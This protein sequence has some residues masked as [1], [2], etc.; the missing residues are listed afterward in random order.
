[1]DEQENSKR[2]S[3]AYRHRSRKKKE[4]VARRNAFEETERD[5]EKDTDAEG[6]DEDADTEVND[7]TCGIKGPF[8]DKRSVK[9][10][11]NEHFE[12]V[13]S[14]EEKLK[15]QQETRHRLDR[16]TMILRLKQK[17]FQQ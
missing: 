5:K 14:L 8:K 12:N 16:K 7:S 3:R 13:Q 11:A 6:K 4:R 2:A 9:D 10:V 17:F 1:M 15:Q